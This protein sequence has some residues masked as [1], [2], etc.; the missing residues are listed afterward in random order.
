MYPRSAFAKVPLVAHPARAGEQSI[1]PSESI[2]ITAHYPTEEHLKVGQRFGRKN[3]HITPEVNVDVLGTGLGFG[4]VGVNKEQSDN[5]L[6]LVS[7]LSHRYELEHQPTRLEWYNVI[8]M[9]LESSTHRFMYR[10]FADTKGIYYPSSIGL[11]VIVQKESDEH[12]LWFP[13]QLRLDWQL[14]V[15]VHSTVLQTILRYIG[16]IGKHE[17]WKFDIN[18]NYNHE[19]AK[20]VLE[21][22]RDGEELR[23]VGLMAAARAWVAA[24]AS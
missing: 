18:G 16:K 3:I 8:H 2:D 15:E 4:G 6:H 21:Q 13:F 1:T 5:K 19:K 20:E 10:H 9:Y 12:E 14:K 11:L 22:V 23:T 7:L 24:Q 17:G